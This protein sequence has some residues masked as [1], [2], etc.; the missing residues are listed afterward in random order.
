MEKNHEV[1]TDA[2]LMAVH[3]SASRYSLRMVMLGWIAYAVCVDLA[4]VLELTGWARGVW[5]SASLALATVV[6][7]WMSKRAGQIA[8]SAY[9][10]GQAVGMLQTHSIYLR[11]FG[12][13]EK[14]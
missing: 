7:R 8:S 2:D 3:G 12:N 14:E 1:T 11:A 6:A 5:F 4:E 10:L 13:R 9:E